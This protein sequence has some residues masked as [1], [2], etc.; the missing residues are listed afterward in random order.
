MAQ[1]RRILL[2][3]ESVPPALTGQAIVLYELLREMPEFEVVICDGLG[4]N[5]MTMNSA[6]CGLMDARY[7]EMKP[8]LQ[9]KRSQK[10]RLRMSWLPFNS[11][12]IDF[13][14][15]AGQISTL[16]DI[17]QA[18]QPDLVL[19]CTGRMIDGPS[20]LISAAINGKK[21][22]FFVMDDYVLREIGIRRILAFLLEL[23]TIRPTIT[24]VANPREQEDYQKRT[25]LKALVVGHPT[26]VEEIT[27]ISRETSHN[28]DEKVILYAGSVY[29]AQA[30]SLA[31]LAEAIK[32]MERIQ[33]HIYSSQ[34]EEAVRKAG[35]GGPN[36]RVFSSV[37]RDVIFRKMCEADILFLPLAFNSAYPGLV[38]S[39]LPAKTGEYMSTSVP[40]LVHAPHGSYLSDLFQKEQCGFVVDCPDSE[41]LREMVARILRDSEDAQEVASK[42]LTVARRY[43]ASEMVRDRFRK[44]LLGILAEE[45]A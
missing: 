12:I 33:L 34:N 16:N 17:I 15:L 37:P 30:D 4:K 41:R 7:V 35:I 6:A 5:S 18:E 45:P 23:A 11:V 19:C 3:A 36:V 1:R 22:V 21:A 2:I 24:I 9:I 13:V 10:W 44:Y 25:R 40:I 38:A 14:N 28:N 39:S 26:S 8:F 32:S 31:R 42:A 43:F 27:T 29:M 20:A